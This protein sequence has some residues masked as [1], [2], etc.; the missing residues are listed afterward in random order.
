[1]SVTKDETTRKAP[2]Q[3]VT[4]GPNTDHTPSRFKIGEDVPQ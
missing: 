4:G 3:T 1:V 2:S